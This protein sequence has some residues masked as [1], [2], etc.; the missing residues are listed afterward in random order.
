MRGGALLAGLWSGPAVLAAAA[1]AS[2]VG[3]LDFRNPIRIPSLLAPRTDSRGLKVFDL[4]LHTGTTRFLPGKTTPT[5]GVNGSSYLGPTLR[6]SR[7]DEVQMHVHNHLPQLTTLHWHG[8]HLPAVDD[9]GPHQTIE[10]GATWSPHWTIDQPAASLF[11]HPHPMGE[12][13]NQ[14]YRGIAGMLI[15]GDREAD[16]LP[17]PH[18]YGVDD[19]PLVIQDK[20]LNTNG[21][22]NFDVGTLFGLETGRVGETILINGTY[23]PHLTV[24]N[25]RVRFR[26]LNASDA[27]IYNIGFVDGRAF[28]LVATDEGLVERPVRL[29]RVQL[30]PGERAEIVADFEPGERVVLRSFA[31]DLQI[32][33]ANLGGGGFGGGGFGG[34]GGGGSFGADFLRHLNGGGERLDLLEIRAAPRLRPSPALPTRL[35]TLP[36]LD[37]GKAVRTRQFELD[38]TNAING[39]QMDMSRINFAVIAGTTEIWE[40]SGFLPHDFHIHGV[41]FRVIDVGGD[42]P[43]PQ[44]AGWKDT[45]YVPPGRTV[46][47]LVP[48]ERYADP[49]HP[50][51]YHCHM[52]QHEDAGMMGQFVVIRRGQESQVG[53]AKYR[54]TQAAMQVGPGKVAAAIQQ[55][56][57]AVHVGVNPNKALR[58]NALTLKVAKNG[59]P[60]TGADVV[61]TF[62]ML[63]MVMA[64]Q[65]HELRETAPG[66]YSLRTPALTMAGNWRLSFTVTPKGEQPFSVVVLDQLDD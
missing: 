63:D 15:I 19:I 1:Q 34:G 33:F 28:H 14:T 24:H 39:Q 64:T 38:R 40:V 54:A 44:I 53:I 45:V 10:S 5:W 50:Y 17:L 42:P 2:N 4:N 22:L 41:S 43:P 18:D 20:S 26:L 9:G 32:D 31:P 27:R 11:Y 6:M 58:R 65:A 12:T 60:I 16:A 30:A 47:L 35:A 51:M 49:H 66:T 52:L 57:F 25:E 23:N 21:S 62:E 8:M 56:G 55:N 59:R 3:K 7:G 46:R 13:A 36:P 48:F 29:A 37:I 61:L